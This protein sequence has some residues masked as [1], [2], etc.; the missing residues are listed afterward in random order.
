[1]SSA[2]TPIMTTPQTAIGKGKVGDPPDPEEGKKAVLFK[3]AL[4]FDGTMNNRTNSKLRLDM[5]AA[6]KD[7]SKKDLILDEDKKD[8]LS[9]YANY[10]SNVAILELLNLQRNRNIQE[11]SVYMEGIGTVDFKRVAGAIARDDKGQERKDAQG[12]SILATDADFS[13]D[14]IGGYAFGTGETGI[15]DRVTQGIRKAKVAIRKAYDKDKQYIEKI[16]IDVI[17][18]SRGAAAARHF[19]SRYQ[20]FRGVWPQQSP[21]ELVMNFVGLFETVSSYNEHDNVMLNAAKDVILGELFTK[22]VGQ[23]KLA[24]GGVPKRII[25]LTAQDEMRHNFSLTTIDSSLRV[26]GNK[27]FQVSMPGVHS[28]IGGGYVER[29]PDNKEMD[30]TKTYPKEPGR[31]AI[32]RLNRETRRMVNGEEKQKLVAAGWYT[33]DTNGTPDQFTP[34]DSSEYTRFQ[35][36][37]EA[38]EATAKHDG[39][40]FQRSSYMG[41]QYGSRYLSNEYQYVSLYLMRGMAHNDFKPGSHDV[42]K[43]QDLTGEDGVYDVPPDLVAVRDH[44]KDYIV[45][46]GTDSTAANQLD[47]AS[48]EQ[49]KKTRNKYLHRS[50]VL[51]KDFKVSIKEKEESIKGLKTYAA[52]SRAPHDTRVVYSDMGRSAQGKPV[53]VPDLGEEAPKVDDTPAA[54]AAPAAGEGPNGNG[55]SELNDAPAVTTAPIGAEVPEATGTF[56]RNE[57]P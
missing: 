24:M 22:N 7:G 47:F 9:S 34:I 51:L 12:N 56:E 42:M 52:Y 38:R 31:P 16:T 14:V 25:H 28:D 5:N 35:Q 2:L 29:D 55:V 17:G 3:V 57:T 13:N 6:I 43:F 53:K 46:K 44:F 30:P 27:A 40:P 33:D 49:G 11:V 36:R 39:R 19:V 32:R 8:M 54:S 41:E 23:L 15:V 1:M 48:I 45:K 10:Y 18:F 26:G 21:P 20:D 37:E 4:F 50:S